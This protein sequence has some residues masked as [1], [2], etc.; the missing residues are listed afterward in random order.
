MFFNSCAQ[1]SRCSLYVGLVTVRAL[2]V[3]YLPTLCRFVHFVFRMH[4]QGPQNVDRFVVQWHVVGHE[5]PCQLF[6]QLANVGQTY[7][8]LSSV[9]LSGV[10]AGDSRNIRRKK[11]F[12]RDKT[13]TN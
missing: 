13:F 5:N 1:W 6:R 3:V 8:M 9:G 10:D 12:L 2:D 7:N 11:R 4:Q